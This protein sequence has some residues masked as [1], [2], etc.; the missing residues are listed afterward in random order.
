MGISVLITVYGGDSP[1]FLERALA[2]VTVEQTSR[3]DEVVLVMDG[4]VPVELEAVVRRWEGDL[5]PCFVVVPLEKN[6]GLGAALNAGLAR[7]SHPLVARMDADD[8]ALADRFELQEKFLEEHGEVDV[9]GSGC[10]E[11]D[12]AGVES[13]TRLMPADHEAIV[14]AL[15]TCPLIHP[16]IMYRRDKILAL[17]GYDGSLRRRQDYELW[18]RAAKQ[19][20]R[21]GNIQKPL[22]QYRF[23]EETHKR[24]SASVAWRQGLI[25][26]RGSRRVGLAWWKQLGCFLPF[27]RSLLPHRVQHAA[28]R[29]LGQLDPRRKGRLN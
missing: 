16:T 17:G 23:G 21:F 14:D 11:M 8:V 5:G 20:L 13:D 7:C 22:L 18:F 1:V 27:A 4:P 24:Q 28:Y 29:L 26:F 25:G 12:H 19:G 3:P 2:S 15:W 6:M 9:L 10:V